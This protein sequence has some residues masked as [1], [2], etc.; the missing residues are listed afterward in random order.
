M[1]L[2]LSALLS[3]LAGLAIGAMPFVNEHLHWNFWVVI[4]FSGLILGMAFGGLQFAVARLF[5]ARI[6][7]AG[8]VSLALVGALAYAATDAGIWL[9]SSID[10]PGQAPIPL[11]DVVSLGDYMLAR[12]SASSITTTRG[13]HALEMG[14]T[15]T[16]VTYV[17]DELGALL[18]CGATLLVLASSAAYC[19]PCSRYRKRH[20]TLEREFPAGGSSDTIWQ[21]LTQ[22]AGS[23][24]NYTQLVARLQALPPLPAVTSRKLVAREFACPK[25]GQAA[26]DIAVM[27][28]ERNEWSSEGSN[29]KVD[30][31][32]GQGPGLRA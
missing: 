14:Q 27:R 25:C 18:G 5:Q 11:S 1:T 15:A 31:L 3:V 19:A 4:P 23:S 8:G 20:L 13:G 29:L 24:A 2:I 32:S 17:V 30:A 7:A 22:L 12:L 6:M 26:L 9:T 16:I 21:T 10:R 28:R